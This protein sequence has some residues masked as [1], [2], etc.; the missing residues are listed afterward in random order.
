MEQ[1]HPGE[2]GLVQEEVGSAAGILRSRP[3]AGRKKRQKRRTRIRRVLF[4]ACAVFL[5][6][7]S[8]RHFGN[9]PCGAKGA[10]GRRA[11]RLV[12]T[13]E[14]ENVSAAAPNES[15]NE[16]MNGAMAPLSERVSPFGSRARLTPESIDLR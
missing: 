9:F 12:A 11:D 6:A 5:L 4:C 1:L 8:F 2:R 10:L 16:S 15:L 7:I 13:H 14:P 3:V